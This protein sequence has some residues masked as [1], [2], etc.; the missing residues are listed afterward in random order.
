[1]EVTEE[2]HGAIVAGRW[3]QGDVI[4]KRSNSGISKRTAAD[5]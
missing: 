2:A 5:P 1:M 4:F 3:H